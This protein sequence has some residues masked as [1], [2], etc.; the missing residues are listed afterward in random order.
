M[1]NL[2]RA[3]RALWLRVRGMFRSGRVGGDFAT[4]VES[5]LAM[6]IEDGV[7]TGLS[8][9]E[10][11]RQALIRLGGL[12]QAK[13]AQRER[14]GLPVVEALGR[15]VAYGVRTL[16]KNPGFAI[17]SILVIAIGIG[18]NAA[19]FT[20]VRSVLL[21]PLPFADPDR[22]VMMYGHN[23]D[24]PDSRNVVAAGDFY[25]WQK[26]SQGFE[27]MAIWRWSGY[28][29]SGE[30]NELPEMVSAAYGSW[31]IFATLG[32]QP[33]LGRSFTA[34]D[35][36][37]GANRT[38]ILNWDLFKRRFNSDPAIVGSA[39]KLNSES[40]TVI[41]VLPKWFTYPDPVVQLWV[42]YR[43]EE[44][45]QNIESHFNHMGHVVARLRPRV[46][47]EQ[48]TEEASG[49]QHQLFLR[50][51]NAGPV[52]KAVSSQPLVNEVVGEVKKPLYVLMGAVGCLLLIACLNLSNLLV[53]RAAARRKEIAIR[54]ALGSSRARLCREQLT[55]SLLICVAGGAVGLVLAVWATRWLTTRWVD[56]PRAEAVH[57]DGVVVAFAVG[58]T[59]VTGIFSG[60]LP[61]I[62]A[63]SSSVLSALQDASRAIG[64]SLARATLRK[65]LLTAEIALTV[66]LL[67]CAGLL[68][69]SFLRLRSVELGC[70]TDNVLT[71][72]FFLR[73]PKY[74]KTEKIAA[75]HT[76]FLEK[77]RGLPGVEAAGLT[78]VVPGDGYYGDTPIE[79]P[80]HPPLPPGVHQFAIY[81]T[82]DPGYF[83]GMGIPL[84]K[85]RVFTEDMR[86]T[87]GKYIVINQQFARE[88][89]SNEESIGKHV[90]VRWESD[91]GDSYEVIGVVGNTLYELNR[92]VKSMVW[93]PILSGN[94]L[95]SVDVMLIVHAHADPAGLALP[96]QKLI[97]QMDPDLP[98]SRVRT[99]EQIVGES[100]ANS[101]F[102]ATLV[103]A[104]A[105]LSLLLA[106]VGLYGVLSYL[107]TQRTTEIGIRIALGARR[108]QLLQLVMLDGLRPALLGLVLGIAGS[109]AAT[110]LIR[111]V[112]YA[113]R[114]LDAVVFVSVIATLLLVATIACLVPAWRAA[115]VD[116][117]QALRAE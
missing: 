39:I 58:I 8:R 31:N 92:P 20:V 54:T 98:V 99:M 7:R 26:A 68:F 35:D 46:S 94:P 114:P 106:A 59:L 15:D 71:M 50:Y 53:A 36:R 23:P 3:L 38:V 30:K 41:G 96:I 14:R 87:N 78:N 1:P 9:E 83:A 101:S 4:E 28:N 89:F 57:P 44:N 64:G 75:F 81:R 21:R 109:V 63:T 34:E 6:D 61:A 16:R 70:R 45:P 49:V 112:L 56:M 72:K 90:K 37:S 110:Q 51:N 100:T 13:I 62:S 102:S 111:S 24:D 48:A 66:V 108:G 19:L 104:F 107:V 42:P 97:A 80:E 74:E 73:R 79:F 85:G 116:P 93:F 76:E 77:V 10:A 113:T 5:H 52:A 17:V 95:G 60:L 2:P 91:P 33:V 67:V 18:A 22:L 117:I 40:Y 12:E 55:E 43:L 82:A 103:L 32:V 69:K 86:L 84:I 11:R 29:L 88:F 105:G 47:I 115:R 27:K 65:T 25:E